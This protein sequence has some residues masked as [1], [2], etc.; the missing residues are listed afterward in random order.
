M[1][2][3]AFFAD[4]FPPDWDA[5]PRPPHG[6]DLAQIQRRCGAPTDCKRPLD[7]DRDAAAAT[8]LRRVVEPGASLAAFPLLGVC[9][10]WRTTGEAGRLTGIH[11]PSTVLALHLAGLIE[12]RGRARFVPTA[13]GRARARTLKGPQ[14]RRREAEGARAACETEG[15]A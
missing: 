10:V 2:L 3:A 1:K 5:G 15:R 6:L 13:L 11:H 9:L 14:A 8:L 4:G 7:L 12:R